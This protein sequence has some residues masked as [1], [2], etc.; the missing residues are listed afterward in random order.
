LRTR[1]RAGRIPSAGRTVVVG[2]PPDGHVP[3]RRSAP[4][5]LQSH[6]VLLSRECATRNVANRPRTSARAGTR[7]ARC[8]VAERDYVQPRIQPSSERTPEPVR[9]DNSLPRECSFAGGVNEGDLVCAGVARI[10][11]DADAEEISAPQALDER[12]EPP[13]E[14]F[15]EARAVRLCEP[16]WVAILNRLARTLPSAANAVGRR[17]STRSRA[18]R[19]RCGADWRRPGSCRHRISG[20]GERCSCRS[21]ASG[22]RSG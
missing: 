2:F 4:A 20:S 15:G 17:G 19:R 10:E 16:S 11:I 6:R 12:V 3:Q 5:D 21:N 22:R 1:G 14:G 18:L 13:A 9:R 7:D 8:S